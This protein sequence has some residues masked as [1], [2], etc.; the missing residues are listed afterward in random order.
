VGVALDAVARDELDGVDDLLAEPVPRAAAH[1]HDHPRPAAIMQVR[2]TCRA[3]GAC[4]F[5]M[6]GAD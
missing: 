6:I 5:C 3:H 2:H 1:R 4:H